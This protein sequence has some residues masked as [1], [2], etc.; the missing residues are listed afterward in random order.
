MHAEHAVQEMRAI[1]GIGPCAT[2]RDGDV[3]GFAAIELNASVIDFTRIRPRHLG[4]G[5]KIPAR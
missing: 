2:G 4:T 1:D 3:N 5:K